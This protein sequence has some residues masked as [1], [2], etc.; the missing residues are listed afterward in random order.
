MTILRAA[1][2][3]EAE[4]EFRRVL[5]A[6]RVLVPQPGPLEEAGP[7]PQARNPDE[8]I[9]LPL[10]ETDGTTFVPV[11]QHLQITLADRL[12]AEASFLVVDPRAPSPIARFMLD[13]TTPFYRRDR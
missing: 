2:D 11:L 13:E 8:P 12:D 5:Y 10:F 1:D 4:A 6:S 9:G 7:S 3:P